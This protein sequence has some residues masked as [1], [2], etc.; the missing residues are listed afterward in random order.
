MIT[1]SAKYISRCIERAANGSGMSAPNPMVGAVLVYENK[2][3][4]EGFHQIYGGPHAEVNAINQAIEN[5]F[6]ELL[7]KSV[8]YVS[9]EPCSHSG[10]TPPCTELINKHKIP[11]VIIGCKD[12]FPEVNG[13]GIK[14][15]QSAGVEVETGV[16][17]KEC[18]ELNRRFITYHTKKRPYIILKYAQTANHFIAPMEGNDKK[19][20]NEFTDILVHKWRSEEAAIMVGTRTAE[21][22]NP[23]LTVRKWPGKNPVRFVIDRNLRLPK[24]LSIFDHKA[25]TVIFNEIKS[26]KGKN[27][28]Y[29][30]IDFNEEIIKQICTSLF[31][32]NILSVMV[33]GGRNLLNQFI[34][35]N[36]WDEARIITAE[37]FF[38]EG[39]KSPK[40][41]GRVISSSNVTGDNIVILHPNN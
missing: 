26:E 41:D 32:R 17:E 28:D 31:E 2:I 39:I 24:S 18:T 23:S 33:E 20:S 27:P 9:L 3:I 22:D 15:L 38:P 40:I 11:K 34:E 13:R 10:K 25:P 37:K 8:L 12:P 1:A 29:I 14:N 6:G 7:K 35:N 16:L 19:I 36:L 4:G 21:E 30:K 5:G